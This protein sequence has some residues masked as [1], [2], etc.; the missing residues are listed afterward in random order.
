M[1]AQP[2]IFHKDMRAASRPIWM[3]AFAGFDWLTLRVS[4]QF[5][6]LGVPRGN[7]SAVIVIPGFMGTDLYLLEMRGWLNRIGYRAF[8][9][10]IGRNS[11]C[12]DLLMDKLVES[13]ARASE[14]T[15][16]PVHLIGHSLGGVLARAAAT[17]KPERVASVITLGSPYRGIRS[18]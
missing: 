1:A 10:G 9:S 18:H 5:Y 7:G 16:G 8:V 11:E 4:P 17:L 3:E 15:K 12:L 14:E 2:K 13:I 6:G